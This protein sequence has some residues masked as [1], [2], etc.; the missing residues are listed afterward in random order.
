ML[1]FFLIDT[2]AVKNGDIRIY[3]KIQ[4]DDAQTISYP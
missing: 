1:L 2:I 4:A 3:L